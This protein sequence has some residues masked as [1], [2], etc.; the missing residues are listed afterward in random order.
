MVATRSNI[1]EFREKHKEAFQQKHGVKV[2]T[3]GLCFQLALSS[4][5]SLALC[6]R[7]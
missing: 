5:F 6:R 7:S 2:K 4:P 3:A 1:I